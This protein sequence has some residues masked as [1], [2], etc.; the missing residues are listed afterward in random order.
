MGVARTLTALRH[1]VFWPKG[2]NLFYRPARMLPHPTRRRQGSKALFTLIALASVF[3]PAPAPAAEDLT[4]AHVVRLALARNER[5]RIADLGVVSAN[6]AVDRARAA[7]L[8]T[9]TLG[10]SDTVRPYSDEQNGRTV[11]RAQAASGSVTAVQPLVAI[12]A[13]PIYAAS[14]HTRESARYDRVDLRR[15]LTFDAAKAF[16]GAVTQQ[17]LV[18]AAERRLQRAEASLND[19]RARALA[20]L[21]STND[22]TRAQV[23]RA[24]AL[25]SV[26][27][28]R[29]SLE[30]ARI[31]LEYIVDAPVT[32]TLRPP[33]ERLAPPT[34]DVAQLTNQALVQRPDLASAREDVTAASLL[35]DEP[36]L[37]FVPT[38]NAAAQA[39]LADQAIAGD[40]YLDTTLTFN[41]TWTIWD[42]GI[43]SSDG[44][45][46][47]ATAEVTDLQTRALRR[48]VQADVRSAI[49]SLTAARTAATIAEEAVEA[50]RRSADET[51][52]L[53]NQGLAKAIELINANLTRFEAEVG[54]AAAYLGLRQAELDLRAAIG[55]FPIDG[56]Q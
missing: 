12:P 13:Y 53:Y 55:L 24:A 23:E 18:T 47:R 30:Q 52:V 15:L 10:A 44:D 14:K 29:A 34:L 54:L 43:R 31:G 41:L 39:R 38:L 26:N 27:A 49:V 1:A 28:A 5:S 17:R 11:V 32:P 50:A 7:F 25:Q 48:R 36:A 40:R 22:V 35:A 19:T 3:V 37:R 8:P 51:Q 2:Q 56:I 16:F 21:V 42:A 6:A 33:D 20:Q 9:I 46:R 45:A 4:L